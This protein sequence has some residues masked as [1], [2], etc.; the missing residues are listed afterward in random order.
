MKPVNY[1]R[2]RIIFFAVGIILISLLV[3]FCAM[4]PPTPTDDQI[5]EAIIESN[6]GED[7][8]LDFNYE[9]IAV[10]MRYPGKAGV[11]LYVRD[12]TIQRNFM[13]L[14]DKKEKNFYAVVD[15]TKNLEND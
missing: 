2:T 1:K 9:E 12:N 10:P 6:E 5:L 14:Y 7:Q 11:V 3:S 8:P 4:I 15:M 13:V